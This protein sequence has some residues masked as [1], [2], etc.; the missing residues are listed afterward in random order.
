MSGSPGQAPAMARENFVEIFSRAMKLLRP[1]DE[2]HVGQFIN[3]LLAPALRHAAHEAEHHVRT[4]FAHIG[5]DVLHLAHGLALGH[6]AHG[7]GV[8]QDDIRDVFSEGE[9]L[10]LGHELRSDGLAV[11]LDHLAT[12]GVDVNAG[13]RL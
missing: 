13:H 6:V 12:V 3:Q 5:G 11:T 1:E 9:G 10:A 7:T 4:I 2:V 8:E